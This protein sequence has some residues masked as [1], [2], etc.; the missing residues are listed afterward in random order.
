MPSSTIQD[1]TKLILTH[2]IANGTGGNTSLFENIKQGGK[3]KRN[4]KSRKSHKSKKSK[5]KKS[6]SRKTKSRKTRKH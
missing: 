5:S 4:T 1:S 2:P 3:G 6:K